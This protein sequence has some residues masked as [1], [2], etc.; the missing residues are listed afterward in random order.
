MFSVTEPRSGTLHILETVGVHFPSERAL[1]IFAEH[2]GQVD[3]E[4]QI[5]R[6]SPDLVMEAMS[7]A[8]RTYTQSGRAEGTDLTLDGTSSNFS[9]D[10]CGTET[11]DLITGEPVAHVKRTWQ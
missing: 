10:G 2:G 1:H 5:V 11:I 9:S 3:S 4:A 8:P 6:L 7:Y